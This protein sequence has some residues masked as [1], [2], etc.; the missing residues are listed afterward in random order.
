M[1]SSSTTANLTVKA[2]RRVKLDAPVP[3]YD[4]TMPVHHNF[5]LGNG[6][7]VH[8]TADNARDPRYQEVLK[9]G[10]KPLNAVGNTLAKVLGHDVV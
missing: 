4:A 6:V 8:N 10:G 2:V 9:C 3:V 5:V 7:V 1:E